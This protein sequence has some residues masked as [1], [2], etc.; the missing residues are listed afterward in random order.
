MQFVSEYVK[1]DSLYMEDVFTVCKAYYTNTGDAPLYLTGY[2]SFCPCVE[3][4]FS[5]EPLVPG[6]TAFVT[7]TFTFSHEGRFRHPVNFSYFSDEE[8]DEP[9]KTVTIYGVVNEK[10]EEEIGQ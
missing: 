5:E 8:D 1:L 9:K 10:R 6:D 3:A 4:D 2:K 7:L